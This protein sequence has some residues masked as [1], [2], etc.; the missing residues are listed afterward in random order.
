M[1][2]AR[3]CSSATFAV[4]SFVQHAPEREILERGTVYRYL[5]V[6]S[7]V[8][9]E[10]SARLYFL[11]RHGAMLKGQTTVGELVMSNWMNGMEW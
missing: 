9:L 4:Q 7:I 11:E 8:E 5:C 10:E 1:Q 6:G 3:H 2:F